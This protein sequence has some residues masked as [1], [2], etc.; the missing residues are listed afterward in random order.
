MTTRADIN[1]TRDEV[2]RLRSRIQEIEARPEEPPED[3][4][5]TWEHQYNYEGGVYT[6]V[7][8]HTPAGWYTTGTNS[9]TGK[10]TWTEIMEFIE[11][12][13]DKNMWIA[14]SWERII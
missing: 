6:F 11:T 8:V 3:S 1:S 9:L 13:C 5:V 2:E 12:G 7:A 14:G 4:V 10:V